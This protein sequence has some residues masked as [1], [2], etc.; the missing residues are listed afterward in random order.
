MG[1]KRS[2]RGCLKFLRVLLRGSK[3]L[4]R[5]KLREKNEVLQRNVKNLEELKA[6]D[7]PEEKEVVELGIIFELWKS[8]AMLLAINDKNI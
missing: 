5:Q 6:M 7:K 1:L 4:C 3:S 8:Q 2:K